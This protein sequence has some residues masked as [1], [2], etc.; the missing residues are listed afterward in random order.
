MLNE[1]H[2]MWPRVRPFAWG[3][4]VVLGAQAVLFVLVGFAPWFPVWRTACGILVIVDWLA[5]LALGSVVHSMMRER[6]TAA[7]ELLPP[8]PPKDDTRLL[9]LLAYRMP[10]RR[11]LRRLTAEQFGQDAEPELDEEEEEEDEPE[12]PAP[13]PRPKFAWQRSYHR[14]DTP[15]I[16][17][18]LMAPEAEQDRIED[19]LPA[20]VEHPDVVPVR[21][22]RGRPKGA[23]NKPKVPL[24]DETLGYEDL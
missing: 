2:M 14:R 22:G 5:A 24:V 13:P 20:K 15:V 3:L 6:E 23:K 7:E 21:R 10:S 18:Q 12:P 9:G 8:P 19:A 16:P 11:E 4:G 1:L 17:A